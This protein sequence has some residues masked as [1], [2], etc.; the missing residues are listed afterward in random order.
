MQHIVGY[1]LYRLDI[2]LIIIIIIYMYYI[3]I[4]IYIYIYNILVSYNIK[5]YSN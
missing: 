4:Y 5:P 2:Y 1:N 3:Y